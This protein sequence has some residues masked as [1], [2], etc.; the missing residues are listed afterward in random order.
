MPC[1]LLVVVGWDKRNPIQFSNSFYWGRKFLAKER[2]TNAYCRRLLLCLDMPHRKPNHSSE[3]SV[4]IWFMKIDLQAINNGLHKLCKIVHL[5]FFVGEKVGECIKNESFPEKKVDTN[6]K[7][8]SLFKRENQHEKY[9][10]LGIGFFSFSSWN[11]LRCKYVFTH[12]IGVTPQPLG[13]ISWPS[14]D[15]HQPDQPTLTKPNVS[16]THLTNTHPA[17]NFCSL[18]ILWDWRKLSQKIIIMVFQS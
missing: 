4:N 16:R 13:D 8:L 2:K 3:N 10:D 5:H 12:S 9:L 11:S 14:V 15:Q 18:S 17:I 1:L 6:F 7:P